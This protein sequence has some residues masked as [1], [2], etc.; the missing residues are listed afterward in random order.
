MGPGL[1]NGSGLGS[2]P[3][4]GIDVGG[5]PLSCIKQRREFKFIR[6][7]ETKTSDSRELSIFSSPAIG[8]I[9][10]MTHDPLFR[11][12][13]FSLRYDLPAWKHAFGSSIGVSPLP[14]N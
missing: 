12:V 1:G 13:K 8:M 5:N 10:G 2:G 7:E 4:L 14:P 6:S 9:F 3:G 11:A